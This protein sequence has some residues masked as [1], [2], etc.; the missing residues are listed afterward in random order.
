MLNVLQRIGGSIGTAV[1]AV[2]LQ[3]QIADAVPAAAGSGAGGG[4][5]AAQSLPPAARERLADPIAVAFGNTYWWSLALVA[6]AII[7]ALVMWREQSRTKAR[8]EFGPASADAVERDRDR[9]APVPNV[10]AGVG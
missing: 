1:L 3:R 8:A 4:E 6:A 2:V 5:A 9:A 10:P 7:P